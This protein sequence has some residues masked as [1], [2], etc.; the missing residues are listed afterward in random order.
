MIKDLL[1]ACSSAGVTTN[2]QVSYSTTTSFN[3]VIEGQTDGA[4]SGSYLGIQKPDPPIFQPEYYSSLKPWKNV[5]SI[6]AVN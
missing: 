2:T 6:N 1:E 3:G 4:S 5:S